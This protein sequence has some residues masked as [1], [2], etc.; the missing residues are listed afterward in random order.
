MNRM[1]GQFKSAPSS[2]MD[3]ERE[4]ERQRE[5]ESQIQREKYNDIISKSVK[6]PSNDNFEQGYADN[7]RLINQKYTK[8]YENERDIKKNIQEFNYF[9]GQLLELK[10]AHK[11]SYP[12]SSIGLQKT[13]FNEPSP[14]GNAVKIHPLE[15][16]K[17]PQYFSCLK[18]CSSKCN[19]VKRMM[20]VFQFD[21]KIQEI[22][23]LGEPADVPSQI[24]TD[25]PGF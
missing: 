1:G 12:L 8:L 2:Y 20:A 21:D 9:F 25:E 14:G 7:L 18:C 15:D 19:G 17:L 5:K 10:E 6:K 11:K 13:I 22:F 4:K 23:Q 24:F 3:G 16:E